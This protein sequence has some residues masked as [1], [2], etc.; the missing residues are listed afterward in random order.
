MDCLSWLALL[1]LAGFP[2]TPIDGLIQH[3]AWVFHGC[4]I[5]NDVTM[6]MVTLTKGH[7]QMATSGLPDDITSQDHVSGLLTD[8]TI[9]M[10]T[11][12]AAC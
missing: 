10:M 4:D 5:P 9:R 7:G 12:A 6:T 2:V 8:V 11:L 3:E 1:G